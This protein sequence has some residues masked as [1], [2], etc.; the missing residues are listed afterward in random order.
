MSAM[1]RLV[2]LLLFGWAAITVGF[3]LGV[4]RWYQER[5]GRGGPIPVDQ[6]GMLLTPLRSRFMPAAPTV[7]RFGL[8]AG[9][10]VLEVGPG[11]GY[12]TPEA[13]RAVGSNGRV[14]CVDLQPGMLA[15]LKDRLREQEVGTANPVAGDATRLP[16]ANRSVDAAFLVTVLGEVPDKPAALGELRRVLKPSGKLTFV[17]M[18]GDPDYM[19]VDTMRDLCRAFGFALLDHQRMWYGYSMTFEAPQ[20]GAGYV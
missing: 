16:L 3:I 13:A 5:E 10:T 14:V 6:A 12:Y 17:E 20:P 18:L 7:E 9:D 15:L 8:R 4:R 19:A 2:W 1:R 11:P